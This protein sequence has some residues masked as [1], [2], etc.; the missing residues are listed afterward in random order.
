MT[1]LGREEN[2]KDLFQ[3]FSGEAKKVERFPSINKTRKPILVSTSA[4]QLI[5][6]GILMILLSCFMFFLGVVRGKNLAGQQEGS[7]GKGFS[8]SEAKTIQVGPT[9]NSSVVKTATRVL[10]APP[11]QATAVDPKPVLSKPYTIVLVTYKKQSLAE[12]EAA[13]LKKSGHPSFISTS[14]DYFLVCVGQYAN[15]S[16]AKKALAF[17]SAKYKSR[18]LKRR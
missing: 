10:T 11:V 8:F 5:L 12:K 15:S 7:R 16:D 3:E 1:D 14:G 2:Q 17:F 4:E 6:A 13:M 18:Y 9:Q